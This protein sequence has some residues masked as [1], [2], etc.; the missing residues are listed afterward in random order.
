MKKL[1]IAALVVSTVTMDMWAQESL[2]KYADKLGIDL[3]VAVGTAFYNNESGYI[4]VLGKEFNAVVCENEMKAQNTQPSKGAFSFS[5]ADKLVAYAEK[6]GMKVRGHCF[7]WHNQNPGW[8]SGGSWSRETLLAAMKAHITGVA[9]HYKGKIFEWDVVNEA[10]ADGGGG[11]YRGSFWKNTIGED[12]IDSAFSYAH[13]A[14]PEALLF[15][16]DYSTST[17]NAKSTAV[18]NKVKKMLENKVPIHGVGFQSHQVV[19]EY[20]DNFYSALKQNFDRFAALGL[21]ISITELDV[22]I[23]MPADAAEL[24]K[25]AQMYGAFL[26]ATLNTPACKT[27]MIWGFTDKHSWIP[28]VF[29]GTGAGLIYNESYVAKPAYD[30]LLAILKNHEVPVNNPPRLTAGANP[31]EIVYNPAQKMFTFSMPSSNRPQ[32][33]TIFTTSGAQIKTVHL[34]GQ[35]QFFV[36]QAHLPPGQYIF[37]ME[38]ATFL[39]SNL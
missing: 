17:I 18:Y 9:T 19:D 30:T 35:Q 36:S 39:V 8:L 28:S 29:P 13:Q 15:Y 21:K 1:V 5:T 33:F 6:N 20:N 4:S 10:F 27:F 16:N 23:N 26:R 22:R 25:Q 2:R 12:F 38:G 7:V 32:M 31:G 34:Q 3:G 37:E 14:D 24:K 11:G